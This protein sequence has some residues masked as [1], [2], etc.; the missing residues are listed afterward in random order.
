MS[1]TFL[2]HNPTT[3][4]EDKRTPVALI[5]GA[6]AGTGQA[7][8]VKFASEGYHV[9]VVRRGKGP[10]RLL[11]DAD[12]SQNKLMRFAQEIKDRGGEATALFADGT[13]VEETVAL[14]KK[15]EGEIGPIAFINY[16]IGAQVGNR[17]LEKTSYRI[18]E[19]AWRMGSL[20]AFA[21]AKE[22]APYMIQRGGGTIV[23]TSS[24]SAYRG[25]P[26]Q[27][28]HTA[29]MGGRRN[30]CQS[31]SAELN[32]QGIHIVH[33]NLDGLVRAPE[34][35]F[36]LMARG[37]QEGFQKFVDDRLSTENI[38]E[39]S[40]IADTYFHLHMQ[41][42]GTWTQDLDLRPWKTNAWWMSK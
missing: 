39:P 36:K 7:V 23:Y 41:P 42:K 26:G 2:K 35:A 31:L 37:N 30:L 3:S 29:A 6:G 28:A 38:L 21:I 12:D 34:T 10:N 5:I 33:V 15:I 17:T 24:T 20:G 14:V 25:N 4:G 8:A 13:K 1:R 32:P 11:T 22:A 19:L 16:N 9:V 18:F 40:S 27:H